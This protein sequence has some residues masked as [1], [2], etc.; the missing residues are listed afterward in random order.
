MCKTDTS[1][2][3]FF[4]TDLM[5]LIKEN[6]EL[7]MKI[8]MKFAEILA[9]RLRK[10]DKDLSKVQSQLDRF[11]S[12]SEKGKR[13]SPEDHDGKKKTASGGKGAKTAAAR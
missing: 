2:I 10:T 4:R 9:V 11:L 3:G 13:L 12:P 5:E 8:V 7:G 1:V 6:P